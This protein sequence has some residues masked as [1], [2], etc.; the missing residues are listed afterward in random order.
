MQDLS[1]ADERGPAAPKCSTTA[2]GLAASDRRASHAFNILVRQMDADVI[3]VGAGPAGLSAALVLARAC[4]QV[5]LF[6][7]GHPRNA[8]A[9]AT[10]GFLTRDGV[11]PHDLRAMARDELARYDSVRIVDLEVTDADCDAGAF[12]VTTIDNQHFSAKKLLLATGVVDHLPE[13]PGLREMY[14]TTVFHCPYCDGYEFRGKRLAV[15]GCDERG[16]G[17]ALE[18]LGWSKDVVLVSDGPCGLDAKDLARLASRHINVRE[19]KVTRLEGK[20]GRLE[21]I[22][23]ETGEPLERD[24][25][26]FTTGQ[27]QRSPLADILGCHFN[28]KGTVRTGAYETTHLKG[29][30]V[31]G[32]AS[33][34]VQWI[35]VAAAE[36]AEAAYSINQDLIKEALTS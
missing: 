7:H 17:L 36:G 14:G 20:E 6:D 31:A 22:F 1:A 35:V 32:D 10:H 12:H 18:L 5:L 4:R 30:Y 2:A 21:R 26:F 27:A 28:D 33:R 29:L 19:E 13:V 9:T 25:V 3:I 8:A 34:A 15:Y 24:A 11:S 16:Y 23:F